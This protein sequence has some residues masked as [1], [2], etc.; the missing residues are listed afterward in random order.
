MQTRMPPRR[1]SRS[2]SSVICWDFKALYRRH[3]LRNL[4][5][6][7]RRE[8]RQGA[9]FGGKPLRHGKVATAEPEI[10]VGGLQVNRR[11]V[12]D[13]AGD[14]AG[15]EVVAQSVALATADHEQVVDVV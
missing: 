14:A 4:R 13:G 3:D 2:G 10:R 5:I 6:L 12:V 11:R 9:V 8:D 7:D 1:P 15:V